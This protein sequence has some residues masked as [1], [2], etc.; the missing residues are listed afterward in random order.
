MPGDTY[1]S[2]EKLQQIGGLDSDKKGD[3][4][5]GTLTGSARRGK[6]ERTII[7]C[8]DFLIVMDSLADAFAKAHAS[9]FSD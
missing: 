8:D 1:D 5:K 4:E 9:M 6:L 7:I 2:F 3:G